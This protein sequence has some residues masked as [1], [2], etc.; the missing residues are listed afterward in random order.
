MFK[1]IL[2]AY[3]GS[4]PARAALEAGIHLAKRT[5]GTIAS[6]SVEEVLPRYAD[7]IDEVE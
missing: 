5:R 7:T 6:V 1:R 4:E 3:D 2:V